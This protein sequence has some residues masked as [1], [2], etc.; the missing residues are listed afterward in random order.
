[1]V[2][3]EIRL[4]LWGNNNEIFYAVKG[5]VDARYIKAYFLDE[6]EANLSLTGKIVKFY[7]LKPDGTQIYNDC[8][9]DT[10]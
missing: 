3:K 2:T 7:A 5:E 9:V 4:K 8:T 6:E 10:S 1:M